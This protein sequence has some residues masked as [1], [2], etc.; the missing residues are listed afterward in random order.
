LSI[1]ACD[2]PLGRTA[3]K[4][5]ETV[6]RGARSMRHR[7]GSEL[8]RLRRLAAQKKSPPTHIFTDAEADQ[9]GGGLYREGLAAIEAGDLAR[10][11]RCLRR[12]ARRWPNVGWFRYRLGSVLVAQKRH[13]E[14]AAVFAAG[15]P[16]RLAPALATDTRILLVGAEHFAALGG[17]AANPG[18]SVVGGDASANPAPVLL[19]LC[20]DAVYFKLY[21]RAAIGSALANGAVTLACHV[22]VVNPDS[23]TAAERSR[24]LRRH[25]GADLSFSE[26]TTDLAR[27]SATERKVYYAC[28]RFQLLPA[29]L[30]RAAAPIIVADV[31]QLVVRGLDPVL[32]MIA[33]ADV[34]LIQYGGV[35]LGNLLSMISASALVAAATP[36]ARRYF[37]LVA[38]YVDH[39]LDHDL[40]IWHLDQAALCIVKLMLEAR[41]ELVRI[42]RL[43]PAMLES[44][45][46]DAA[47]SGAPAPETIFWSIT[48]SLPANAAKRELDLFARYDGSDRDRAAT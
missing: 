17:T 41:D 37:D 1:S 36:G 5:V 25:A 48:H 30:R 38:A 13:E 6:L 20:C 45:A 42:R 26:E 12:A 21:A 11:E 19:L 22:H 8:H 4:I 28:R 10:G 34:G 47:A 24:I 39:C 32:A 16:L 43:D 2:T 27:R 40:W 7:R 29:I 44:T 3:R 15:Y 35:A 14:A 46:F 31:D 9:I 23:E 33:D 18:R